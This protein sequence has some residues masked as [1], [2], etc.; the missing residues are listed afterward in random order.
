MKQAIQFLTVL[1]AATGISQVIHAKVEIVPGVFKY[2]YIEDEDLHEA[3]RDYEP[4]LDC[5][6]NPSRNYKAPRKRKTQEGAGGDQ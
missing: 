5:L 1:A 2:F 3:N 4:M 6:N